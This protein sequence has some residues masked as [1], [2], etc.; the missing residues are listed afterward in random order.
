MPSV[1]KVVK[2][3]P[4]WD[5]RN[6]HKLREGRAANQLRNGEVILA[7]NRKRT[8]AR[9]IDAVGAVHD[10]YAETGRFSLD[11][12]KKEMRTG[13]YIELRVGQNERRRIMKLGL[14]A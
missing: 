12:L 11:M 6:K 1:V 5:M 10:Y 2:I 8:M 14:A 7:F 3:I 13:L 4:N 9:F